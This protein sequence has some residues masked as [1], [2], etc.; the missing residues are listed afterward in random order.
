MSKLGKISELRGCT[1]FGN[2]ASFI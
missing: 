2:L 1:P